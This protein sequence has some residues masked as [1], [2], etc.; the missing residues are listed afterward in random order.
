MRRFD[1]NNTHD[2]VVSAAA[3]RS[4]DAAA[5]ELLRRRHEADRSACTGDLQRTTRRRPKQNRRGGWCLANMVR[6]RLFGSEQN[7]SIRDGVPYRMPASHVPADRLLVEGVQNLT[8]RCGLSV[9]DLGA[10]VGQYGRELLGTGAQWQGWDGAGDVEEYTGGFVKYADVTIPLALP[11]ADWVL[12]LE[13]GEHLPRRHE[14]MFIRNLH[15]HNRCGVLLSWACCNGGHQHINLRPNAFVIRAFEDL[16]YRFDARRSEA[17]RR[18]AL[19][20]ALR[21][22]RSHRVYGWFATSLMLFVRREPLPGAACSCALP[23]S[24]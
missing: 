1:L 21:D 6:E 17:M 5:A 4:R 11:R 22:N 23:R 2:V 7:V 20:E 12:S 9:L 10:G 14:L 3:W 15:A 13:V 24:P 19:R 16:G 8:A 18:P